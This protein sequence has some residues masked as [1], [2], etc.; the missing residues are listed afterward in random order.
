MEPIFGKVNIYMA[1]VIVNNCEGNMPM[2][3]SVL[4]SLQ[5]RMEKVIE[6]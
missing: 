2:F 4:Q 3:S 5:K 1:I 6:L